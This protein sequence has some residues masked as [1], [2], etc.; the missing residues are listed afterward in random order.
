M[1]LKQLEHFV[2]AAEEGSFTAAARRTNIVQSGLSMSVRALEDELGTPLFIR[3]S[4]RVT[5]TAAGHAF[6]PEARR[7]LTAVQTARAAV[8]GTQGLT[9]GEL[10]IGISQVP[11]PVDRL[12][13]VITEF[14]RA[15]PGV[16]V[17]IQ[18]DSSAGTLERVVR[19]DVDLG[20]CSLTSTPH[21]SLS[22]IV[23][24]TSDLHLACARGHRFATRDIVTLEEIAEEPFVDMHIGWAARAAVDWAFESAGLDRRRVC[25]VNDVTLLARL[26]EQ[27]LGVSIIPLIARAFS[28]DVAYVP[29]HGALP[30]W[31]LAATFVGPEPSNVA[32]KEL[33]RMLRR[34]DI[35]MSAPLK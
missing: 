23:L 10:S 2:A 35:W 22:T 4:R 28:G 33:L 13:G 25:E 26:V 31:R 6:L 9:R 16:C 24:A 8:S 7:A 29:V 3:H 5:L 14:R 20:L 34:D 32:A 15:H 27:G 30:P 19:G 1:E 18:Q 12:V 11:P 17:A 21:H